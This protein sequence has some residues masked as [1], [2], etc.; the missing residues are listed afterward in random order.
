[1]GF[2]SRRVR[3]MMAL[4]NFDIDFARK[5]LNLGKAGHGSL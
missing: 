1:M 2:A 3:K 5:V 4:G